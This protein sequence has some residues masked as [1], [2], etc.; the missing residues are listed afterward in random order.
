[1]NTGGSLMP[2]MLHS[3]PPS[4]ERATVQKLRCTWASLTIYLHRKPP[5]VADYGVK[6]LMSTLHPIETVKPKLLVF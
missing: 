4:E 3:L 2:N 6:L 5:Q 1:M